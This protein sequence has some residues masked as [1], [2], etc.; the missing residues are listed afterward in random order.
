M[1]VISV[2]PLARAA[3][4][5]LAAD[6]TS[7]RAARGVV[8][9]GGCCSAI[10]GLHDW[11]AHSA[12]NL[13]SPYGE[14]ESERSGVEGAHPSCFRQARSPEPLPK[15][16]RRA[17]D[18]TCDRAAPRRWRALLLVALVVRPGMVRLRAVARQ[19]P[20]QESPRT[21]APQEGVS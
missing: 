7:D 4:S 3:P 5:G 21:C 11:R 10:R 1:C 12:G 17:A 14:K 8:A 19:G 16:P 2:A 9:T 15:L 6:G 18:G 20:G 13:V